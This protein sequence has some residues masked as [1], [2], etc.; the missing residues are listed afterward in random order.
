MSEYTPGPWDYKR[1]EGCKQIGPRLNRQT[2]S[3]VA[4]TPGRF[5]RDGGGKQDEANAR[6]IAAAPDLLE[7]LKEVRDNVRDDSP[8]MWDR[9]DA[10]IA[11]ATPTPEGER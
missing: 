11:K 3:E 4:C 6:L 5:D 7:A 1:N 10:A 9:V 8:A 2:I